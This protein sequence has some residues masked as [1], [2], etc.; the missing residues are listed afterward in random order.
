MYFLA[1]NSAE[2]PDST[3]LT[4]VQNFLDS[5]PHDQVSRAALNCQNIARALLHYEKHIE[6]KD[7]QVH[8]DTLQ[9]C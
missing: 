2:A 9:V 3:S 5:L 1:K 6:G 4:R 8:I 7:L